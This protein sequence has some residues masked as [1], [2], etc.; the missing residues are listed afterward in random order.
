[1]KGQLL[2]GY[3]GLK[4]IRISRE[5]H[6]LIYALSTQYSDAY[7]R[8]IKGSPNNLSILAVPVLN[9][10]INIVLLG[11]CMRRGVWHRQSGDFEMCEI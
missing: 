1:V 3:Q 9:I 7:L 8:T 5:R 4:T 11:Y 6:G 10:A 2:V